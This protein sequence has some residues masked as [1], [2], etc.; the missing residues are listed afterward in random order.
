MEKLRDGSL[1]RKK[2]A[3][4]EP[5]DPP[6]EMVLRFEVDP[7]P[8]SHIAGVRF[9]GLEGTRE[10]FARRVAGLERGGAFRSEDVGDA[11]RRLSRTPRRHSGRVAERW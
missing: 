8:L 3:G 5:D 2:P 9:E 6:L 10:S 7:G 11:R 1:A 4:D